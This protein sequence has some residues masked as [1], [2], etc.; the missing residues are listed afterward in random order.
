MLYYVD[1]LKGV[2]LMMNRQAVLYQLDPIIHQQTLAVNDVTIIHKKGRMPKVV[3]INSN[4][5]EI[6]VEVR[7]PDLDSIRI[8]TNTP[9]TFT[10]Y[11]Y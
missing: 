7:Y 1:I 10:A 9:T 3:V 6:S 2:K 4:G 11:I 5:S 8:L